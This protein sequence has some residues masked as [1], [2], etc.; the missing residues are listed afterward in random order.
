MSKNIT[1]FTITAP[2]F[3]GLNTQDAPVD[4]QPGFALEA[5]NCVI[6]KSG[7]VAA[8]KGWTPSNTT[9]T[10][11]GSANVEVIAELIGNDGTSTILCAG[12]GKLFKLDTSS[13]TTLTTLTY[14][15]GGVAPTITTNNW[16]F[17]QLNGIAMF[18]QRGYDPLIY[19]PSVSTTTFR[20][21]SEK[22][23]SLGT[24]YQCNEAISAYGRVW[25][26]DTS[27]DKQTV[28]W[29][30]LLT[31]HIWTGGTAGSLDLRNV[32]P[33]GGDEVIGLAAHN[34]FLLIFGR[35][36]ILIYSGA[37]DPST[38][39]LS[40]SMTGIGCS[41]RD[42]IQNTGEDVIFLANDG[43]RSL[44]RTIQEKS[45]PMRT[46]SK[47]VQ[48]DI[49][50]YMAVETLSNVKAIY[51]P[52]NAFYVITFPATSITYCFDMRTP[53]Q[54]GSSRVTTWATINPKAF[55]ETKGKK[56]YI[57]KG[58]YVG[59][60]SGY[61]DNGSPYRLSYF[62][63]WI[64]FGNP[65]QTSILKKAILT[66]IGLSNQTI[67]FKWAYDFVQTYFSQSITLSGV[68]APAEYGIAEYGLAEYSGGDVVANTLPVNGSSSGKVL[69]FGLEAQ[70]NG[71]QISIQRIDLLTKDGR[72]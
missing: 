38:M 33:V 43:V 37:D 27:T 24:V 26:A 28:V 70:V 50:S 51:S 58:G 20:R 21:L 30:D 23:G 32:W 19:D 41:S 18:W 35:R 29:S 55:C 9:T 68:S 10:D 3:L 15:G 62:T 60:Y 22:S 13:V 44:Q 63:T 53:L 11:L 1:P 69:Q 61:D 6:D 65:I 39:K 47:N 48:D 36:Q 17:T 34:N 59:E 2:G 72:L 54:D 4:L 16:K 7:R 25:A 31:P 12:N 49:Q 46:L 14:G 67:V 42:S 52:T 56:L 57:G 66:L 8:R 45:S 5:I 64:D 40:D 71:Y